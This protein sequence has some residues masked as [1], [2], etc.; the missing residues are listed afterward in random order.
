MRHKITINKKISIFIISIL[1]IVS[2]SFVCYAES[3]I[4]AEVDIGYDGYYKLGEITPVT[5]TIEN[6]LKDFNG[7]VQILLPR[8]YGPKTMYGAYSSFITIA[9]GTTKTVLF[10]IPTDT[11]RS[12][13]HIRVIDE[14][15]NIL[16]DDIISVAK[17]KAPESNTIGVLSDNIDSL[18]YLT[19]INIAKDTTARSFFDIADIKDNVPQKSKLLDTFNVILINDYDTEKLSSKQKEA[20]KEWISGGGV[21]L[22]GTGP[23]YQKTVKGLDDFISFPNLEVGEEYTTQEIKVESGK[24]IVLNF[25]FGLSSFKEWEGRDDFIRSIFMPYTNT[26]ISTNQNVVYSYGRNN[27]TSYIPIDKLPSMKVIIILLSLFIVLVGPLCYLVLKKIDKREM[28]W[29]IV[30]ALSIVFCI[31][32]YIWGSGIG[33]DKSLTNNISLIEYNTK[34]KNAKIHTQSGISGIRTG[35]LNI[36]FKG[37]NNFSLEDIF[38]S[39]NLSNYSDGDIVFEYFTQ[40]KKVLLDNNGVWDMQTISATED[41]VIDN[42]ISQRFVYDGD[43]IKGEITNLSNYNLED[44]LIVY[45]YNYKKIGDLFSGD[46]KEIEMNFSQSSELGDRQIS[47]NYSKDRYRM[48]DTLYSYNTTQTDDMVLNN[49]IKR[50][51][52]SD[53][54]RRNLVTTDSEFKIIAWNR[55]TISQNVKINGKTVSRIDRNLIVIPIDVK[56]NSGSEIT[57][58]YGMIKPKI[59]DVNNFHNEKERDYF[60]GTNKNG[61]VIFRMD[62]TDEMEFKSMK[63]DLSSIR[64]Y[65]IKTYLFNYKNQQW[66]EITDKKIVTINNTNKDIYYQEGYGVKL[67][68]AST[69]HSS[70][71][72]PQFT[73]EGVI[74]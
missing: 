30:P 34:T 62:K 39:I 12:S 38:N 22:I 28:I 68:V 69:N 15:E 43:K 57:I 56:Y 73:V 27:L 24:V 14:K 46:S 6:N 5:V 19:L 2:F 3:N 53:Y 13:Y 23:N 20:L 40:D 44:A 67:K 55:E 21:L 18:R 7:K 35:K 52:L 31:I 25:D 1:L 59:I 8:N 36:E 72:S 47:G 42:F 71:Q 29:S 49:V 17:P 64:S 16:W 41:R 11:Y 58:P 74:K 33:F 60:H 70:F 32:I 66:N 26:S 63:V 61:F 37:D 50:D 45:G 51:I 54:F 48:L 4:K 9:K 65:D 10:E